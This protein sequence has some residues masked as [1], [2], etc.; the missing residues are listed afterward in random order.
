M[1]SWFNRLSLRTKLFML[2]SLALLVVVC[3]TAI[4]QFV[5]GKVQ[6]GGTTYKGIELKSGHIDKIARTRL[7]FNLINTMILLDVQDHDEDRIESLHNTFGKMDEVIA[8][9]KADLAAPGKNQA[10]TCQS[11]HNLERAASITAALATVESSWQEMRDHIDKDIIPAVINEDR[12]QA[13]EIFQDE[14]QPHFYD[15]MV[16]TKEAVDDLRAALEEVKSKTIDKATTYK[17]FFNIAA[18]VAIVVILALSFF[19]VQMIVKMVNEIVA[20]LTASAA[21][22]SDESMAAANSAQQVAE[23]SSEMAASLEQTSATLEEITSRVQQ[24]DENANQANIAM[25]RNEE[26]GTTASA[27]VLEMQKS[28]QKIK[29][30][31]DAISSFIS[32]IEAIAFQTNL[33]A[34]NAAVEAA[35]AG[36]HGQGFAVV[37]EEVRNLA[38]RSTESARKSNDLITQARGNV[39]DGLRKVESVVEQTGMVVEDARKVGQLVEEITHASHEQAQGISQI[40]QGVS[41]MDSGTQQLAANAE[42]LA[43]ASEAV[44]GQTTQLND[45]IDQ[46]VQLVEGGKG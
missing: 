15:V 37:A 14:Y 7:N 35:R 13:L 17:L 4:A 22:I 16:K 11:C 10:T 9:L 45:N 5:I 21:T 44:T 38:H 12:D 26:I 3:G 2:V 27:T 33:L 40:S 20:H 24:N 28:M 30:D 36:E 34:L 39:D 42:E 25:K 41:Q 46:L 8:E 19:F 43:A 18:L 29:Q 32:D 31:T 1:R 23:M 6:I